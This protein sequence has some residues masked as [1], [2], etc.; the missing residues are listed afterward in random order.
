MRKITTKISKRLLYAYAIVSAAVLIGQAVLMFSPIVTVLAEGLLVDPEVK[1]ADA[2][3][4]LAGGA[5]NNGALDRSTLTRVIHG[6]ELYKKGLA[7]KI[8]LSGGNMPGRNRLDITISEK[9]SEAATIMGVP[10][11]A[12]MIDA[13]SLR[14]YENA[15]ESGRI[16]EENGMDDAILVTSATHMKRALLT[17]RRLGIKVYPAPAIAYEPF[18]RDPLERLG[19]SKTVMREY[20]GM[21]FYRWKGWI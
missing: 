17:F 9:M 6:V 19:M 7:E 2:I 18:V 3:I 13:V 5:Y 21:L 14:T 4:I 10:L 16:M 15:V 12:Q 8:I 20:A 11:K 1:R